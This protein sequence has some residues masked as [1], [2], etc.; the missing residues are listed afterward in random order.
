MPT[1]FVTGANRGIGLEFVRQYLALGW[2][3]IAACRKPA[4]ATTLLEWQKQNPQIK[5]VALDQGDPASLAA[6]SQ[7]VAGEPIDVLINSAGI[8]RASGIAGPT[9]QD[10]TDQFGVLDIESWDHVL[11]V[12]A[13]GP[14]MI[15][16]ALMPNLL[17]GEQKK[18]VMISSRKGSITKNFPGAL[19]YGSAK[20]AL[21]LAMRNIA[22]LMKPQGVLA[23]S[24]H[25]GWVKTDM[26]GAAADI[27][28]EESVRGMREQIEKL[29]PE[30]SG[31]F[32]GYDGAV[33]PW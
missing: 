15:A 24:F 2:R 23:V 17:A 16:Q 20:A 21:N 5:L 8:A 12:N 32:Y 29:G 14:V 11:R 10:Q 6:L 1:L 25:P 22:E 33:W 26:G 30:Q 4:E 18:L 27:T 9:G 19:V 3:V 13:I 28:V 31:Q 7:Q